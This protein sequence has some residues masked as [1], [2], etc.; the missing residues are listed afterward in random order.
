MI[1]CKGPCGNTFHDVCAS[2]PRNWR[3]SA[4][5]EKYLKENFFCNIC[6]NST[7]VNNDVIAKLDVLEEKFMENF[8]LMDKRIDAVS[9]NA[10]LH[11]DILS[12]SLDGLVNSF[13]QLI[14]TE[15]RKYAVQTEK[16][17]LKVYD[18]SQ[19][20]SSTSNIDYR[21]DDVIKELGD[22][23]CSKVEESVKDLKATVV[24]MMPTVN[25]F[26][27]FDHSVKLTSPNVP[28][29]SILDELIELDED[30]QEG[31]FR[32]SI[33][34]T[35]ERR[36][37]ILAEKQLISTSDQQEKLRKTQRKM[38]KKNKIDKKV[39]D[40]VHMSRRKTNE[41]RNW[42]VEDFGDHFG[43]SSKSDKIKNRPIKDNQ[44]LSDGWLTYS[45][46]KRLWKKSWVG[47]PISTIDEPKRFSP[48][49]HE[50]LNED[51]S[52]KSSYFKRDDP[53]RISVMRRTNKKDSFVDNL[54]KMVHNSIA[55][56][57]A[58]YKNFVHGGTFQN[59]TEVTSNDSVNFSNNNRYQQE[60]SDA[61]LNPLKPPLVKLTEMSLNSTSIY[62]VARLRD[63]RI[64]DAVR[65]YLAF[66]NDN[67]LATTPD[68]MSKSHCQ[69]II[70]IEG[71][72]TQTTKLRA[73]YNDFK[74]QFG[75]TE[76]EIERDL[77]SLRSFLN[78]QYISHLQ[79]N[80]ETHNRFFK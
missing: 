43:L 78:S 74:K 58:K 24:N 26:D 2:L 32:N 18:A 46:G 38:K 23:I 42:V 73:I 35:L 77:V 50:S 5:L 6:K 44:N 9:K 54:P 17:F 27:V 56:Y 19:R 28:N 29:E 69:T 59:G 22:K 55:N 31:S 71:L 72:P 66:L 7:Y 45:S 80:R 47:Q 61:F 11:H 13:E 36:K 65:A 39:V 52:Q 37:E 3:A 68:G 57:N 53:S 16:L 4:S 79:K 70:A 49:S 21:V 8:G 63:R 40:G 15:M 76:E 10:S 48:R 14:N 33:L 62:A 60:Q 34:S 67:S 30:L 1:E 64:F 20:S 41:N 25:D 51:T 12:D 75:A